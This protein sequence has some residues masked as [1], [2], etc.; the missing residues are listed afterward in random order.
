MVS[1]VIIVEKE[2]GKTEGR[3]FCFIKKEFFAIDHFNLLCP[4]PPLHI[5]W[6]LS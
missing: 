3:S 5:T 1:W 4:H 2:E 6:I